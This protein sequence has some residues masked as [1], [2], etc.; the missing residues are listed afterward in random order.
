MT[1][2]I[3]VRTARDPSSTKGALLEGLACVRSNFLIGYHFWALP[4]HGPSRFRE[5]IPPAHASPELVI[6]YDGLARLMGWRRD[7]ELQ[8]WENYR[9]GIA[10]ALIKE[11]FELTLYYCTVSKQVPILKAWGTFPFFRLLRNAMSHSTG[12]RIRWTYGSQPIAW[13]SY[14]YTPQNDGDDIA[15]TASESLALHAELQ[16]FVETSLL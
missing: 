7:V 15:L 8:L 9:R 13:R 3:D 10:R 12:A 14:K 6:E 16:A 1:V 4:V 11:S 5:A 2:R